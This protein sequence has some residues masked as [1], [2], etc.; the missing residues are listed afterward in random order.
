VE[1]VRLRSDTAG[2]QHD[3]LRYCEREEN[4]RFGRI[5]FAISCDVTG[6]FKKAVR[7]VAESEW[8]SIYREENGE[9]VQTGREWAE[10][11]FVPNKISHSKHGLEYRY[12]ATREVL[13]Q[14]DLPGMEE[15][16]ELP[17]QTLELNRQRY[18]IF[19]IV[20]NMDWEG[21]RLIVWQQKRCGKSEE[22]HK[23]MKEDLAGGNLPSGDFGENAAWWW[24]MVLSLNLNVIMKRL[25]LGQAWVGKRMKAIRFG[26][27]CLPGRILSHARGLVIR[28]GKQCSAYRLL[29]EARKTI[30]QLALGPSG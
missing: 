23:V 3:L 19:G 26:V 5:E 8:Q 25:V 20:T 24:I 21:E 7:Q 27:I 29:I 15:Q 22:V 13:R 14:L 30:A 18:K 16:A 6:E 1:S 11:C 12:L 10:V 17:F 4:E 28:L 2:Y 9:R